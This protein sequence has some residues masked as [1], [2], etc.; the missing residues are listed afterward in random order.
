[1]R[2]TSPTL[3]RPANLLAA[4]T[5]LLLT[6]LAIAGEESDRIREAMNTVPVAER[7]FNEHVTI[8]AS[9]WMEGRLPGTRGMEYARDYVAHWFEEAGLEPGWTDPDTGERSWLQPFALGSKKDFTGQRLTVSGKGGDVS[10][11][12]G[13]EYE[14]TG[15]GESGEV[16]GGLVFVGYSIDDG[17]DGYQSFEP[18]TDLEG[19]VAIMLRF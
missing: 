17:P 7:V 2:R 11:E 13:D 1:M 16:E 12:L 15:L 3:G 6:P 5:L 19:K 4:G 10:F 9:P 14:F 8:L 18:D